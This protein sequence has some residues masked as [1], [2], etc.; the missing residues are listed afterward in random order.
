[1]N[2]TIRLLSALMAGILLFS[3][4]PA[5]ALA[6]G[7]TG[8]DVKITE[9]R[10]PDKV[11]RAFVEEKYDRNNDGYLSLTDE[12]FRVEEMDVSGMGIEDLTAMRTTSPRWT[13]AKT[14]RLP[15]CTAKTTTSRP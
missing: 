7:E 1:M 12:I 11:F 6:A 10:F 13:S 8:E 2:R 14:R 4:L 3:L 15:V 5:S 9:T